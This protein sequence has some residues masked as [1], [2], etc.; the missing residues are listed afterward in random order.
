VAGT[1]ALD[2]PTIER[3]DL[4][5]ESHVDVVPATAALLIVDMQ[6]DFVDPK[7]SLSV[8]SAAA[9]VPPIARLPRKSLASVRA[10]K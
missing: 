8:A 3:P 6:N 7:G 2:R 10:A 5:V 9:T 4:T 1:R